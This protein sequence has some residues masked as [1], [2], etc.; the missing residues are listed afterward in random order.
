MTLAAIL[1][2]LVFHDSIWCFVICFTVLL[3][4]LKFLKPLEGN[5]VNLAT[6]PETTAPWHRGTCAIRATCPMHHHHH[7]GTPDL[8]QS[9]NT[10]PPAGTPAGAQQWRTAAMARLH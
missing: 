2:A 10:G 3:S 5:N 8:Q 4:P 1:F 6:Q 9:S 7:P